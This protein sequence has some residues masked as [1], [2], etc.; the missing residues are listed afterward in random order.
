MSDEFLTDT[1][2]LIAEKRKIAEQLL[3]EACM[4]EEQ[5]AIEAELSRYDLERVA[6]KEQADAAAAEEQRARDDVRELTD[7]KERIGRA[8]TDAEQMIATARS[9]AAAARAQID[10]LERLLHD[11]QRLFDEAASAAK[12]HEERV[13]DCTAKDGEINRALAAAE[14][15]VKEC[16]AARETAEHAVRTATERLEE[17]RKSLGLS[18][19]LPS[20]LDT[21]RDLAARIAE[22][23]SVLK[24]GT[25]H[26]VA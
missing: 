9:G 14:T 3:L 10:E 12:S 20:T 11:A 8:R 24:R 21:A 22:E 5:A 19:N 23:S 6:T 26:V 4:L 7:H 18:S 13:A 1:Q 17:L 2:R 16:K 15:R 25:S